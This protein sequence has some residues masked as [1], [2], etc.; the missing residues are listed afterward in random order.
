ML[1]SVIL[2]ALSGCGASKSTNAIDTPT[3]PEP[4][5]APEAF[6]PHQQLV[7]KGASLIVADGCS[8]CHLDKTTR[9]L[10]P[11]FTHFAGYDVTLVDGRR[12]L[13]NEYFIREALLHPTK[14]L[15]A[16]YDPRLMRTATEHLHLSRHPEQVTALAAFIE[17]MGPEPD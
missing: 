6:T 10:G 8:S 13:V 17:Q 1:A 3:P 15:I 4:Q 16:G 11:N 9:A 7:E 12:T 14:D 5:H 2:I